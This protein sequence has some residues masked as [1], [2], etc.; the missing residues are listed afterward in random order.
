MQRWSCP[1]GFTST[2]GEMD[3]REGGRWRAVMRS[4]DGKDL[5]L[6]G[7]YREIVEPERIVFTHAWLDES[8]KL[9]PETLVTVNLTEQGG[10]TKMT[11]HQSGFASE[12]ARDG[13]EGGW[14]ESFVKLGS[15]IDALKYSDREMVITRVIAAPAA[16]VFAAFTDPEHI[17]KWW[18]PNGFTTTT[19]EMDFRVGGIW[20]YTMH[21]P[22][23]TD[24]PNYVTYTG[25]EKPK[26]IAYDHGSNAQ[27]PSEFKA[28]ITF[29]PEGA[30]TQVG[31]RMIVGAAER[32]HYVKFGA[33][34]GGQQTLERL[35]AYLNKSA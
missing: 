12:I 9:G 13:H 4:P 6:V 3:F 23:G 8:G 32:D 18:G 20:R 35:A 30:G 26:R 15:L 2:E 7:T 19:H 17:G 29:K 25:I 10:K 14:R 34:E 1:E 33:V 16:M 21:G 24:Y 11:F 28:E 27:H 5:H 31:L 22:D